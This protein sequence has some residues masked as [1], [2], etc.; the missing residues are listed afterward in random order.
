MQEAV[1]AAEKDLQ[2]ALTDANGAV[3]DASTWCTQV[4]DSGSATPSED[5]TTESGNNGG[6]GD[7]GSDGSGSGDKASAS[8][9][10]GDEPSDKASESTSKSTDGSPSPSATPSSTTAGAK[11]S[12]R[13]TVVLADYVSDSTCVSAIESAQKS[14]ADADKAQTAL[15]DAVAA[16]GEAA[17]TAASAAASPSAS[18][19]PS[20]STSASPSTGTRPSTGTNTGNGN[21]TGNGSGGGPGGSGSGMSGGSGASGSGGTGSGGSGGSGG[22]ASGG[23]GSGSGGSGGNGQTTSVASA[24]ADVAKAKLALTQAEVNLDHATLTAPI[25]GTIASV[26]FTKGETMST[27]DAIEIV[28]NGAVQLT[29]DVSES[30]IRDVKL[31]QPATVSP[32]PGKSYPATVTYVDLMP[33]S[34][35]S[36]SVTY[37]VTLTIATT[38]V[39]KNPKAL[40]DGV[41]ATASITVASADDA[42]LVPVS[43]VTRTTDSAG[44]V[45]VVGDSGGTATQVT[46]GVMDGTHVQ[47]TKGLAAGAVV[48]L[49]DRTQALPTSNTSSNQRR[50]GSSLTG[51]GG[52]FG[53][54]GGGFGGG[55]PPGGR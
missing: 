1:A 34:D 20:T 45:T 38:T 44:T 30:T 48:A 35:S 28:G 23:S 42:V 33:S 4:S 31:G 21:S 5:P 13:G 27:S 43:A 6:Q 52:S 10:A 3:D 40:A 36:S 15:T 32:S 46:L 41:S 50:G 9:S 54:T 51:G 17:Q 39:K 37:P 2:A 19:S 25:S 29:V 8:P 24:E 53:G 22:S 7:G 26:P 49:A 12:S 11:A 14:L 47:V 16:L 18:A 55:A